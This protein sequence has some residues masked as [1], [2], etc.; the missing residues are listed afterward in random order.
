[1]YKSSQALEWEQSAGLVIGAKTGEIG[2]EKTAEYY[3]IEI[4]FNNWRM[5]A[6]G[7]VKL[8]IDT[9]TRKLGFD[10]KFIRRQCSEKI[11]SGEK[12][13]WIRLKPYGENLILN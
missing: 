13:V 3:Q 7:P 1:M 5:D 11:E 2:W 4:K 6:D 10:D 12:G 9:V 8:I